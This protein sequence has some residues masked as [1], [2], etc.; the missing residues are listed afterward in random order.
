MDFG[1]RPDPR[2]TGKSS[3]AL[4]VSRHPCISCRGGLHSGLV[5]SWLTQSPNRS[6]VSV[7]GGFEVLVDTVCVCV[8]G[9]SGGRYEAVTNSLGRGG[10]EERF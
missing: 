10:N 6:G 9:G 7:C 8:L 3:A 4:E 1:V 5:Y 2:K